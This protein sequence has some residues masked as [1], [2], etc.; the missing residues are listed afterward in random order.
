[1]NLDVTTI[2]I[3]CIALIGVV[4]TCIS[5][6]RKVLNDMKTE[7]ALTRSEMKNMQEKTDLKIEQIKTLTDAN[8]KELT[9]EVRA[10]NGFAQ[11]MPVVE[12]KIRQLED[13]VRE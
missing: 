13:K 7:Q 8:I 12:E 2:I 6:N 3:E 11:R 10:H 5:N 4:I 1:M 9:R